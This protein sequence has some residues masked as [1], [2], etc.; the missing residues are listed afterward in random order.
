MSKAGW[1]QTKLEE[2]EGAMVNQN[3]R[4]TGSAFQSQLKNMK[5]DLALGPRL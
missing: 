2:A 5:L 1:V 3:T 4:P